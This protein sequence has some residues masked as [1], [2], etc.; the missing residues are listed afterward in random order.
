MQQLEAALRTIPDEQRE[1]FLLHEEGGFNLD[2]ISRI[3]GVKRETAKSRLRYAIKKLRAA[4]PQESGEQ[5][6]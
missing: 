6:T 3:T 4:L 2:E 1:V 5:D